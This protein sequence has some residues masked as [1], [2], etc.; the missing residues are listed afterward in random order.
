[1]VGVSSGAMLHYASLVG[2]VILKYN[3]PYNIIF[4]SIQQ[5][6]WQQGRNIPWMGSQ[7]IT[8]H[9]S[10]YIQTHT[11]LDSTYRQVF[12]KT[13]QNHSPPSYNICVKN[14]AWEKDHA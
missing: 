1:M 9:T 8:L 13:G 2:Q 10:H 14:G 6:C 7:I 4:S 12:W 3:N 5:D 11:Y